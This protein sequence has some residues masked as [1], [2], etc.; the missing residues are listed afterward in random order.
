[1]LCEFLLSVNGVTFN[2][3][4]DC[5]KNWNE[6]SY[7]I[8]RSDYTGVIRS[9]S[10][11]F[12][13]TKKAYNLLLQEYLARY[14][15]AIATITV[16]VA[17]NRHV[18]RE[19]YT[20]RLDFS[21]MKFNDT[22][23]TINSFDDTIAATLKAN[24]STKYE[25]PVGDLKE[26][27]PLLYDHLEMLSSITWIDRGE[28]ND[29]GTE[30][31]LYYSSL[32]EGWHHPLP[33][34]IQNTEIA[35]NE[36]LEYND[37]FA[38][39]NKST[40]TLPMFISALR[41]TDIHVSI[42]FGL[43][44]YSYPEDITITLYKRTSN[45]D[46]VLREV[47]YNA[48][49]SLKN[50]FSYDGDLHLNAGEGLILSV[51]KFGSDF[52]LDFFFL[53]NFNF[54]VVYQ[55]RDLK[56]V[57]IDLIK[58]VTLLNSL[59]YSMNGNRRGIDGV[60]DSG[61]SR[62]DEALLMAA[63]SARGLENAKIYSSYN[64]FCKWMEAVFGYVPIISGNSV[65]FKHR[66]ALFS[67]VEPIEVGKT[68]DNFQVSIIDSLIYS[69]LRIGF[70]KVDYESVNGLDEFRWTSEFTTGVTMNDNKQELI[71]PY[72][73]DAYGIQFLVN[74]RG[75]D[76]TDNESDKDIFFVAAKLADSSYILTR[77]GYNISGVK[78]PNT[79]FNVMYSPQSMIEANKRFIG[80]GTRVL[81]FASSNGNSDVIIN[82]VS[83][84]ADIVIDKALFTAA[85][86][87]FRDA[88]TI[89]SEANIPVKIT[90]NG[91]S[92]VGY[93]KERKCKYGRYDGMEHTL[94]IKSIS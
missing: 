31:L 33:I 64:D 39:N 87:S 7:S 81:R 1:M 13:F 90:R 24:K 53:S 48:S 84:K 42:N 50:E 12:E 23:L 82:G 80:V 55:S 94:I 10:S 8:K 58:P 57:N 67:D 37:I 49:V 2:L 65:I 9:F 59:L 78:F 88:S 54:K 56:A 89:D 21:T 72:R 20:A 52:G 70:D 63:E 62:L 19:V 15:N 51:Y 43:R 4:E 61:D 66:E 47:D 46:E 41:G 17:D 77:E 91:L 32:G 68:I 83:E 85:E 76:T 75:E 69:S 18:M 16:Y 44:L 60:I 3:G 79:M 38:S 25:Y 74:K 30:S 73:A 5:V 86:I 34:I 92:Y 27:T 11:S 6:I 35:V 93:L 40:S 14:L 45:G 22:I 28:L 29:E 36:V 71:S 26:G